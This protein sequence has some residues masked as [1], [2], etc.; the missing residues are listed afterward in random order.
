MSDTTGL[1]LEQQVLFLRTTITG[2]QSLLREKEAELYPESETAEANAR[3]RAVEYE[4]PFV[5]KINELAKLN[6]DIVALTHNTSNL[7]EFLIRCVA[8]IRRGPKGFEKYSGDLDGFIAAEME[9]WQTQFSSYPS[10]AQ[11]ALNDMIARLG[12]TFSLI[13]ALIGLR[14][15]SKQGKPKGPMSRPLADVVVYEFATRE[16]AWLDTHREAIAQQF[17]TLIVSSEFQK[18]LGS[19]T[20]IYSNVLSRFDIFHK[21]LNS[22]DGQETLPSALRESD[23]SDR[24]LFAGLGSFESEADTSSRTA[25]AD[26]DEWIEGSLQVAAPAVEEPATEEQTRLARR[27]LAM[28]RSEVVCERCEQ[29]YTK[30]DVEA[31]EVYLDVSNNTLHVRH[32]EVVCRSYGWGGVKEV[33]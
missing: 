6:R 23:E 16:W 11:I 26:L 15:F 18:L 1:S 32:A 4:S 33:A 29:P 10:L 17:Q 5:L 21:L 9:Y 22:I 2:L 28:H 8:F 3:I 20:T 7:P 25:A 14:A 27:M 19:S 30:S 31:A 24:D 12:A 13:R